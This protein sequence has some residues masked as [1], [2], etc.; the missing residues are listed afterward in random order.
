MCAGRAIIYFQSFSIRQ[1]PSLSQRTMYFE[2]FEQH[3]SKQVAFQKEARMKT[4]K[5]I[6]LVMAVLV[7]PTYAH[8]STLG[9]V[10]ISFLAG[11]VQM[12]TT[13]AGDWVPAAVNTPLKV[14]KG[15]ERG[16]G[17]QSPDGEVGG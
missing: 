6:L 8:A 4:L 3:F 17:R 11:D 10:R 15:Q 7:M 5:L 9:S 1:N 2:H 16:A 12:R 13:E 14:E